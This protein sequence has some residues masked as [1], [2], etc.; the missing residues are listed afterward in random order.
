MEIID[1][2]LDAFDAYHR[3]VPT[4]YAAAL[5]IDALVEAQYHAEETHDQARVTR[6]Q[7]IVARANRRWRRRKAKQAPISFTAWRETL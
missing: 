1:F 2:H 3:A 7:W 6:L 5:L 4:V